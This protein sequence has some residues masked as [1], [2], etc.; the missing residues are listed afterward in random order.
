MKILAA[1]ESNIGAGP[2]GTKV[3]VWPDSVMIRSRKPLFLPDDGD[4][5]LHRGLCVRID[6]VGKSIAGRFAGRYYNEMAPMAF[7]LP[8]AVS[9]LLAEGNDPAA[10]DIVADYSLICGDFIPK[11]G[12][13]AAIDA[14]IVEASRRNTLKTGDIVAILP[15]EREKAERDTVVKISLEGKTLLENKL[16]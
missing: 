4:Y 6:A 1:Y 14:A 5:F 8:A 10:C 16:K 12:D 13:L 9:D 3:V 15:P 2:A 11:G 7:V